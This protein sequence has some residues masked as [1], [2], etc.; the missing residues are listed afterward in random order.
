MKIQL[1]YDTRKIRI[2]TSSSAPFIFKIPKP[3]SNTSAVW[4]LLKF[5]QRDC[6]THNY[7]RDPPL[8]LP[9]TKNKKL[10]A[11]FYSFEN[12]QKQIHGFQNGEHFFWMR[13][14][15]WFIHVGVSKDVFA[16]RIFRPFYFCFVLVSKLLQSINRSVMR[17]VS[18]EKLW[19]WRH[20]S[21]CVCFCKRRFDLAFIPRHPSQSPA[22]THLV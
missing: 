19:R 9:N 7:I 5:N 22:L 21:S 3:Q 17:K 18:F 6:P 8:T 4:V 15:H 14:R 12:K 16:E 10:F 20:Y 13:F 2:E 1:Y 11:Q